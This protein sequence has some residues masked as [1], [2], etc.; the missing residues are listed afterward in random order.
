MKAWQELYSSQEQSKGRSQPNVFH[1]TEIILLEETEVWE[2]KQHQTGLHS[3][4]PA[5]GRLIA[6]FCPAQK[7]A[8]MSR[9]DSIS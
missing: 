3:P 7:Q 6:S 8:E 2:E 9:A 5:H 4:T 1:S